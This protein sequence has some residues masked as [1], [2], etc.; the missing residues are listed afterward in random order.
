MSRGWL[1]LPLLALL[2]TAVAA[3]DA[4]AIA[5]PM[6]FDLVRPLG[7]RRGELEVNALAQRD[8]SGAHRTVEWA[9]EIEYAFADNLAVEL[10]L[11]FEN[12]SV[13]DYKLGLQGTFGLFD[14]GRGIHGVQYLGL[15]NRVERRYQSSLLYVVGHRHGPRTST[16]T[17]VG[18]GDVGAGGAETRALLINHTSFYDIAAASTAGVEVNMRIGRDRSTLVMPQLQQGLTARIQIQAGIG[19]QRGTGSAW[20]PRAGVRLVQQL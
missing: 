2:P 3:K 1:A 9:P 17:M 10:E 18:V 5:E 15:W 12:R 20:R 4:P 7:A 14:R 8:L 6:V 11:P 19:A 16:L 13:T